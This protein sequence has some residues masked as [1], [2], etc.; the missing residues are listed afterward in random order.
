MKTLKYILLA[1]VAMT[2]F[3]ACSDDDTETISSGIN[4]NGVYFPVNNPETYLIDNG[5][6]TVSVPIVR[7][8]SDEA[9]S[10]R[11]LFNPGEDG[12]GI[13]TANSLVEFAAGETTASIS[14]SFDFEAIETGTKYEMS[15]SLADEDNSSSYGKTVYSFVILYDPWDDLGEATFYDYFFFENGYKVKIQRKTGT[16]DQFRLVN[17]YATCLEEEGDDLVN[18]GLGIGTPDEYLEFQVLQDGL[19]YFVPCYTGVLYEGSYDIVACHPY[20]LGSDDRSEWT[21]SCQLAEGVYQ[22]APYYF[23]PDLGGGW[24][25]TQE[26][27][28]LIVMDGADLSD[29][30]IESDFLGTYTSPDQSEMSA[31]IDVQIGS[32]VVSYQ[33]AVT[34]GELSDDEA[35]EFALGIIDGS[36]ESERDTESKTLRIALDYGGDYTFVAVS[37]DAT[38]EAQQYTYTTFEYITGSRV[39]PDQFTA[40]ITVLEKDECSAT[41][42]IVPV[43]NYIGYEWGITT[44]ELYDQRVATYGSYDKY[45]LDLFEQVAEQNGITVAEL[46]S[47]SNIVVKGQEKEYVEDLLSETEF[48]VYAYAIDATTG[49]G[50]SEVVTAEFTTDPM[51]EILPDYEKWIGVWTVTSTSTRNA[52]DVVPQTFDVVIDLKKAN[53]K[54][55]VYEW[56]PN[57]LALENMWQEYVPFVAEY[58][59]GGLEIYSQD[60][61]ELA[62]GGTVS[63]LP[64]EPDYGYIYSPTIGQLAM[65]GTLTS[66]TT[67]QISDSTGE[68]AGFDYFILQGGQLYLIASG[69]T[70]T[71]PYTLVKQNAAATASLKKHGI[72]N[73]NADLKRINAALRKN[74]GR[75][76]A[77]ISETSEASE[78]V[79]KVSRNSLSLKTKRFSRE[80]MTPMN[81]TLRR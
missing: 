18:A 67:A 38:G 42:Q 65:S 79:K 49:E 4:G 59:E 61:A 70:P 32:D 36:V 69:E 28:I 54:F 25:Y 39:T 45:R 34:E 2:G 35:F 58:N 71:G 31:L 72:A 14:I 60:V 44:K 16:T 57:V 56:G 51:P 46:L 15:L 11:V 23:V 80:S 20:S 50:L 26:P 62:G 52:T 6:N 24:D 30:S 33:Y 7:S 53:K 12:L 13:F 47:Q 9:F 40:E 74:A 29:Y 75:K 41:V 43:A 63:L 10:T 19:V 77:E 73:E 81:N 8:V 37:F 66:D 5:Q 78:S 68:I 1:I 17:P 22:L 27:L 64:I 76:P 21:Y 48:V 3:A 55:Y